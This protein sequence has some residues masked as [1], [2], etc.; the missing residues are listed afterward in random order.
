AV[1]TL[2]E[3]S[4]PQPAVNEENTEKSQLPS[5]SEKSTQDYEQRIRAL[6]QKVQEQQT[7]LERILSLLRRIFY[8][9]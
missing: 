2:L 9:I 3:G 6:E 1:F 4:L 7:V 5:T 8:G